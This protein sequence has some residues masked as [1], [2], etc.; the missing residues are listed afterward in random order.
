MTRTR[1]SKI[2]Q[3]G[4]K[5]YDKPTP[6]QDRM[7]KAFS[8]MLAEATKPRAAAKKKA[9]PTLPFGPGELY[10]AMLERVSHKVGLEPYNKMWFGRMG[11]Q[12]QNTVPLVKADM[13]TFIGW[14]EAGGLDFFPECTFEH[15]I[16]HWATWI[17][18]ARGKEKISQ[19][20]AGSYF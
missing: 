16:K 5:A 14:I 7:L 10:D 18:K 13:E 20:D 17:V 3:A 2:Y 8:L 1:H 11:K 4:L 9:Q 15:V 12:L 6:A 19:S